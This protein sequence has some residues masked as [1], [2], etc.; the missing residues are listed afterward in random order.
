MV[1]SKKILITGATGFV[2]SSIAHGLSS[3]YTILTPL[4]VELDCTDNVSVDRYVEAHTP[5]C[6]IHCA[7]F[8]N[9]SKAETERGNTN[10]ECYSVN[11]FGTRNIVEAATR[12]GIYCIYIS[13]G[14]VFAGTH[15]NPGPFAEFHPHTASEKLSWYGATKALAEEYVTGKGAIVRLSHPLSSL[16]YSGRS[17]DYLQGMLKRLSEKQLYP[18]FTDQLFPVSDLDSVATGL[19]QCIESELIGTYHMVSTDLVSP[20]LLC[21][22]AAQMMGLDYSIVQSVSFDDF[23]RVVDHP[24]RYAKYCAIQGKFTNEMLGLAPYTWKNLVDNILVRQHSKS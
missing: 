24:K 13:T 12:H 1:G 16:G 5:D 23:I 9:N 22:Y 2:G 14:S 8:T 4:R 15:E 11:V 3:R 6:I 17:A 21:T 20:Y 19:T 18:L 7:A 10:G